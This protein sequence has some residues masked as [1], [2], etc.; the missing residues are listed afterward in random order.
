MENQKTIKIG[1]V[2]T[3]KRNEYHFYDLG[4]KVKVIDIFIQCGKPVLH[5]VSLGS[6]KLKQLIYLSDVCEVLTDE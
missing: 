3:V 2:I 6:D 1:N 4:E 5:C